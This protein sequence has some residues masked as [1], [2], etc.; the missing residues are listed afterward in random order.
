MTGSILYRSRLADEFLVQWFD[1][2]GNIS[3][4]LLLLLTYDALHICGYRQG[5]ATKLS[6]ARFIGRLV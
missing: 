3:V 2:Y 1:A 6:R 4:L 5:L